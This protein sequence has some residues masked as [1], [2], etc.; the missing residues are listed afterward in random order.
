MKRLNFWGFYILALFTLVLSSCSTGTPEATTPPP[1]APAE[2]VTATTPE[3]TPTVSL[4]EAFIKAGGAARVEFTFKSSQHS[5]G[6]VFSGQSQIYGEKLAT[7]IEKI[8]GDSLTQVSV[9]Y[10]SIDG[11]HL[12]YKIDATVNNWPPIWEVRVY[13]PY[14]H[15]GRIPFILKEV[16]GTRR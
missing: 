16:V 12:E 7:V 4:K 9:I 15:G 2:E 6:Y 8:A 11:N 13:S 10:E 14:T 1:P 3:P 5:N